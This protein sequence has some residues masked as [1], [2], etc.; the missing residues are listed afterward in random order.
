VIGSPFG[1]EESG[2]SPSEH[3]EKRNKIIAIASKW[4]N[5]HLA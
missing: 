2:F 3:P 1:K 5:R 4:G